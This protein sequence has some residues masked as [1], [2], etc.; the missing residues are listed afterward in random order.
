MYSNT[1]MDNIVAL[2]RGY[3]FLVR[4]RENKP[5]ILGS[6]LIKYLLVNQKV[7]LQYILAVKEKIQENCLTTFSC[8][9]LS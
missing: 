3:N 1:A 6:S 5:K 8:Q 2:Y 7:H 9:F 4:K